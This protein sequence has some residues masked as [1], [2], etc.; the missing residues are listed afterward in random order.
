MSDDRKKMAQ[1]ILDGY[2]AAGVKDDEPFA[3]VAVAQSA[4]ALILGEMIDALDEKFEAGVQFDRTELRRT[5]LSVMIEAKTEFLKLVAKE[6]SD[7][8]YAISALIFVIG[9]GIGV[10]VGVNL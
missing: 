6:Y 9:L 2:R 7:K 8:R 5:V 4:F 10:F 3:R 1:E